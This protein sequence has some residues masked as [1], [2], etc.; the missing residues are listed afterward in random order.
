MAAAVA[1]LLFFQLFLGPDLLISVDLK[2]ASNSFRILHFDYPK[3]NFAAGFL[4]YCNGI[5][6]YVRGRMEHWY[7]PQVHYVI[8]APWKVIYESCKLSKNFCENYN[9]YCTLT[10]DSF[11]V[12]ICSL[13]PQQPPTS[14]YYNSTL[15]NKQLYL[16]CSGR[17]D[18]EPIGII[19]LY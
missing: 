5:M 9:K 2:S 1:W 7:C 13:S 3:V 19:G 15:T 17:Y 10:Q 6:S 16:L 14:C 8:H 11:P 12:T 18:A 4:G